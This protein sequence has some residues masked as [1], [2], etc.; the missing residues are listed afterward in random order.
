MT[1]MGVASG[2]R[3]RWSTVSREEI[4]SGRGGFTA[5]GR[6]SWEA[7]WQRG[8]DHGRLHGGGETSY[9]FLFLFFFLEKKLEIVCRR[10]RTE[11]MMSVVV[12][13]VGGN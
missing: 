8:G 2:G 12:R 9:V 4:V 13:G 1:K 11:W 6:R 7:S 5:K 10:G 3:R